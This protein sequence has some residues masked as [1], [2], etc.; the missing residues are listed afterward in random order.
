MSLA[1]Q[2]RRGGAL[3]GEGVPRLSCRSKVE[4]DEYPSKILHFL[5][6]LPTVAAPEAPAGRGET[7]GHGRRRTRLTLPG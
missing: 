3:S 5:H 1:A 7:Q 2:E 6:Y 4:G